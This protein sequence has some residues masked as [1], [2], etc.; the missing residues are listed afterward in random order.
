VQTPQGESNPPG[1]STIAYRTG[2]WSSFKESMLARLSSADYPALA[3]LKTRDD[4]DFSIALLDAGAV[5]LDILTFYQ[6]RLANE[7]YLRTAT[8][9]ASLTQLS[10]LIGYRP[11]PGVSA[12]TYLAFKMTATTGAPANLAAAAITIPAGVKT[13]SVPPQGQSP[14]TF[15]TSAPILAKADWNALP[16]QTGVPWTPRIGET[17][18]YLVGTATQLNP[19]DAILIVGNERASGNWDVRIVTE[20]APDATN[21]RTWVAWS[22]PLGRYGVKPAQQNPVFYALRQ[23][24]ALFGY[25]AVNPLLLAPRTLDLLLLKS[26]VSATTWD[27]EFN[28][29]GASLVDL[30]A[31]YSKLAPGGWL[32]LIR[33]DGENIRSPAGFVSL[34]KIDSVSSLAQSAYG[35]SAKISRVATDVAPD[36]SYFT[37]TRNTSVLTQSEALA[38]AE[39]PLDYPLY[40]SFI[41]LEVVRNDLA[42]VVAVA[43]TGNRQK[44]MV[45]AQAASMSFVPDDENAPTVPLAPGDAFA[46]VQP[47]DF[48]GPNGT[49]PHWRHAHRQLTLAVADANNRTGTIASAKLEDF[50]L[51]PSSANDPVVTEF[52]LLASF[53]TINEPF[54]H[55]R[56]VLAGPLQNCYDRTTTSVNAN[57]GPATAGASVTDLL[58]SGSA[59][60]PNQKFTLK[61]SPLTYVQAATASGAQST[62]QVKVNGVTWTE[63]LPNLYGAAPTAKVYATLN[64]PGG[65]AQVIFGDGLEG[66][67][68]PTGQSNIVANYRIGIGSAGNVAAGTITTL[69]DRPLG[70]SAVTNP[71][72]A[73][74][75][76]DAQSAGD[77]RA[78][79]PLSVLTLGRPVSIADY[80]NIAASFA[81]VAK[82]QAMWIQ[83]GAYRGVFITVAGVGGAALPPGNATVAAL[84]AA[85]QA[86]GDPTI[87][88]FVQSFL[89]T[90]FRLRADLAF[91]PAYDQNAVSAQALQTLQQTYSF[92]ARGFGQGVSGDEI[93]ALLQ[94]VPGVVAVNV[95]ALEI[96]ATSRAGDL[97]A[98]GFS[99]SAYNAWLAQAVKPRPR[100]P[101]SGS[102][103]IVCPFVPVAVPNVLPLPA[104]ILVLDPDPNKVVLGAM[105]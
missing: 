38:V 59:S 89:E 2:V 70:V 74:G 31:V 103:L 105:Q 54:P 65:G 57:V 102:R 58:G 26:Q 10:R 101:S 79:A 83:G 55:T 97:G 27:W 25:N 88:I 18:V 60:T 51:A 21:K 90:T 104:E 52:A 16:V 43:I 96:V 41:D 29:P 30:D 4:D 68:L 82:A 56:L 35:V 62:L 91:D 13:Q 44:I 15:E 93:A 49:L 80:Q 24:A 22:E 85:L 81:G 63:Q 66:S 32:V 6:E 61:Q 75:G 36:P 77:I 12:S 33:P 9:L 11:A 40:G 19:G 78:N 8:Q 42:G 45:K 67:T 17:G 20:V 48:F 28:A 7:S 92:A 47:P 76:Q 37:Q 5:A 23:R 72:A 98:A 69:V 73:T 87:P 86:I 34:C 71:L 50:T 94:G 99:V 95:T 39:Q 3:P 1:L 53:T 14:Q 46:L 64:L 100:R 84:V